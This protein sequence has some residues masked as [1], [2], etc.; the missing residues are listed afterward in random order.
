MGRKRAPLSK[1]ETV[2]ASAL[3]RIESGSLGEIH[4]EVIRT[5]SME[6]STVQSYIRRLEAKGYVKSKKAGRNNVYSC[7]GNP[8]SVIKQTLDHMLNQVFAGEAIPIF[9]HLIR[10]RGISD[11]EMIELRQMLDDV[12]EGNE[13]ESVDKG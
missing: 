5:Q 12:E 8:Q 11:S 10:E 1:G 4:K 13:N 2:V 9:R 6:Y 3:Y 7:K